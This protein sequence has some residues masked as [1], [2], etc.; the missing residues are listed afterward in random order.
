[1]AG[2]ER[3]QRTRMKI[4]GVRL[5]ALRERY[6]LALEQAAAALS[7][8]EPELRARELGLAEVSGEDVWRLAAHLGVPCAEILRVPVAPTE[9]LS[10][11]GLTLRRKALGS[12]LA[13]QR[14]KSGLSAETAEASAGLPEGWLLEAERGEVAPTLAQLEALA[15]VYACSA[16]R[17]LE[18]GSATPLALTGSG[19]DGEEPRAFMRRPDSNRYVLAAMALSRLDEGA[20]EALED[21]VELLRSP[22]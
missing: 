13:L 11:R 3:A 16:E 6:G 7:V 18:E 10:D 21:V 8:S 9:E 17:L 14:Q 22:K 19:P 12:V 20:L 1:M 4:A 15:A 5:R 2:T